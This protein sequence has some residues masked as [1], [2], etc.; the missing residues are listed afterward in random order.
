MAFEWA[1]FGM[2]GYGDVDRDRDEYPDDGGT[3]DEDCSRVR[4]RLGL[5]GG[6]VDESLVMVD[7]IAAAMKARVRAS[8][9]F[10]SLRDSFEQM[11]PGCLA[12][13]K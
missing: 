2:L 4:I 8:R 9:D 12:A 1:L 10:P 5:K 13:T 3:G 6:E 7:I 11:R